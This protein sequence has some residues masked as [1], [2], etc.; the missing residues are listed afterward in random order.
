[1]S[2]AKVVELI[3]SSKVSFDDAVKNALDEATKTIREIREVWVQDFSVLVKDGKITDYRA[4]VKL[5]F[6]VESSQ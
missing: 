5:T 4:N 3:G 6:L 1:M 2:V